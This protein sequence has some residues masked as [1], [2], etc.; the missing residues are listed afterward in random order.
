MEM[1]F[2]ESSNVE[3]IGYDNGSSTLR[4]EFKTGGTYDYF[5]VP[6]DIFEN[7]RHASSVGGY[8]ASAIKGSYPFSKI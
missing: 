1:Q 4:V 8:L 7:L 6:E 3:R 2:V 5:G